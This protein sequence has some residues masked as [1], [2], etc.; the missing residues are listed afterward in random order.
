MRIA[1]KGLLLFAFFA[2]LAFPLL[3]EEPASDTP[4]PDTAV[5]TASDPA[6]APQTTP[7][8]PA[9][10]PAP[11]GAQIVVSDNINIKFGVLLQPQADFAENSTGGT[12][13]N[14]W[15]RRTRFIASGQV[16]KNAYFFFQTENN[17]LGGAVNGATK[18]TAGFQT[19]DAVI[20]YRYS[21]PLNLWAGLIYLPTSREALKS[22]ATEFMIDV[23]SYAYTATTALAGTGGRDTGFMLRG[24]A[25]NDKLEYRAGLFQGLRDA[26]SRNFFRRIVRLQYNFFDTE[27]YN[28]PSYPGSYFGTKK[29][30]AVGAAWDKQNQYKGPT[31]DL[32]IDWPTAFGC[33]NNNNTFMRLD[34]GNFVPALNGESTVFVSDLGLYFKHVKLGPWARWEQRK[35]Q[36]PQGSK[37]E[38][39]YVVGINW[40]PY[41]SNFNIKTGYGRLKP[42][43]GREQNQLTVQMQFFY[44]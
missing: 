32:F 15:V 27:L 20:E 34:G 25:M 21:K 37:S 33:V 22:S 43:V 36:P 14:F 8:E 2:A 40:Y 31:A 16:A 28:F 4:S 38:K 7:A 3:A 11:S 13:E 5:A 29:I 10:K 12:I 9:K 30:V 6:P 35:F 17:R 26:T 44:F 1:S 23:N 18:S 42:D 41:G 19:T 24:Y 39:R